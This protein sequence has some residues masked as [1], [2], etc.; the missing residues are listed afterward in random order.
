MSP[1]SDDEPPR[2]RRS[3]RP[4]YY[5][6]DSDTEEDLN[7]P[8]PKPRQLRQPRQPRPSKREEHSAPPKRRPSIL[9]DPDETASQ[10]ESR[11]P[12]SHSNVRLRA[13][14][15]DSDSATPDPRRR[16]HV[17]PPQSSAKSG[18]PRV[19]LE[20]KDG[21]KYEQFR[22]KRDGYESEEG[23]ML[24]NAK[25]P[26]RSRDAD[27]DDDEVDDRRPR[28]PRDD[29]E[30]RPGREPRRDRP[31][32]PDRGPR[33]D[34]SD[35]APRDARDP[36]G[37]PSDREPSRRGKPRAPRDFDAEGAGASAGAALGENPRLKT[38]RVYK[39]DPRDR[40]GYDDDDDDDDEPPPPPRRKPTRREPDDPRA[41]PRRAA[42]EMRGYRSDAAPPRRRERHRDDDDSDGYDRKRR[43]DGGYRSGG[44]RDRN[45]RPPRPQDYYSDHRDD[46]ARRSDP[47][48]R[49][50]KNP[51][52]ESYREDDRYRGY[53]K[54]RGDED[55]R[56][57][58]KPP[59]K[60]GLGGLAGLGGLGNLGKFD[61]KDSAWQKEAT[62]AFMTYALPVI[63]KEGSKYARRE[64]QKY[65]E[66]Q[67]GGGRR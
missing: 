53:D 16:P 12:R 52:R 42:P 46:R 39:D 10:R 54:R 56:R 13:P 36:R 64:M 25:K 58:A 37:L 41:D 23:E 35:R 57:A 30:A 17:P 67:G 22:D 8:P 26:S 3:R 48:D 2:P 65:M 27:Y 31:L 34:R 15:S 32:R 45:V 5:H 21:P 18:K 43:D 19:D 62:A 44:G 7:H 40:Q 20:N 28:L 29:W 33:P 38:R 66:K 59:K 1:Y 49:R 6:P 55:D 11:R 63:K 14:D 9:R 51:A 60:S 50:H 47:R 61:F 4:E 24:R